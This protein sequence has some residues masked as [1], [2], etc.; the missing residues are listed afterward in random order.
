MA[1]NMVDSERTRL[2]I[3]VSEA[4]TAPVVS[5]KRC[6]CRL[7]LYCSRALEKYVLFPSFRFDE[8]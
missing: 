1:A 5:G 3:P 2:F 6:R 7:L 4:S 8:P